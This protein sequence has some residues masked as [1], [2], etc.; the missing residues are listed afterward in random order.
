[1]GAGL[2]RSRALAASLRRLPQPR[3]RA[4]EGAVMRVVRSLLGVPWGWSKLNT[5]V[6]DSA[7]RRSL[8]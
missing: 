5:R 6:A 1:M 4:Q 7:K 2:V 3:G 8:R